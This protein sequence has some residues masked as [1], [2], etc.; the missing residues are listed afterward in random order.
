MAI[1]WT[2]DKFKKLV[3]FKQN[4][5]LTWNDLVLKF[6]GSTPNML[7][8]AYYRAIRSNN[9]QEQ[10]SQDI[11]RQMKKRIAHKG[12]ILVIPDLHCPFEHP[13]ALD[14]LK[15]LKTKYK[16]TL[17]INLGDEIDNH[18]I[19]FHDSNPDLPSAGDELQQAIDHLQP[20]Y[21]LTPKCIVLESNHG[22]LV[23]R[24]QLAH[25]LPRK[26]FK[27][28]N[29]IL[30]APKGWEWVSD[31]IVDTELGPIYFCHGKIGGPGKLAAQYGMSAIQ[32]HFHEKSQINWISTPERLMFD[33]HAGCLVDDK[34][35][36]MKYNKLNPKRPILSALIIDC[37]VP[38][39][40]PMLLDKNGRWVGKKGNKR[41][42]NIKK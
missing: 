41:T 31:L 11:R 24:K 18:A 4:S 19:S 26:V 29:E 38:F 33:I 16:P 6:P 8:K 14:F 27:S 30:E 5:D 40:V 23:Y 10:T 25:G 17:F 20:F 13:D 32:G 34:S 42:G 12:T 7:R 9:N 21:N 28:Y 37:G 3:Y 15:Y 35:L 1:K 2:E 39:L 36:A 22:S